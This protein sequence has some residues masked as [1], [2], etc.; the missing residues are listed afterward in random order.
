[1]IFP[2]VFAVFTALVVLFTSVQIVP[3]SLPTP[4]SIEK[5]ASEE[6]SRTVSNSEW[7]GPLAP[8][9]LSPFF[10]ITCLSGM[11]V[12]GDGT[13]VAD[14]HFVSTNPVLKQQAVFWIFLALTLLTSLPRLTKVSKPI[15]QILDQVETYAGIITLV[16][17]RF[18]A[19][20]E[21]EVTAMYQPE[22][23]RMGFLAITGDLLLVVAA[24]IN[25]FVINMVKFLFEALIWLTPFPMVDAV[26]EVCNKLFCAGLM[27]IYAWSPWV[28]MVINLVLFT[29]CALIFR[30]AY[31]SVAYFRAI[32]TDPVWKLI[33]PA[34]G[35]FGSKTELVVFPQ[36]EF[37]SFPKKSKLLL[38]RTE[39]GWRIVR[40]NFFLF[41]SQVV[42]L[43]DSDHEMEIQSGLFLNKLR[44]AGAHSGLLIFSRRYSGQL[45]RVATQMRVKPAATQSSPKETAIS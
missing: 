7:L 41:P 9:A 4:S 42:E 22:V 24:A 19:I 28:A 34:Y 23:M 30:W 26:F 38:S 36:D 45:D 14:N 25:I 17:I 2:R 6:I 35:H 20:P 29:I 21:A 13:F 43:S 8:I 16:V 27:A 12:F 40:R 44:V 31:R 10:G 5:E 1:M 33:R 18:M 32:L 3:H 11:S 15:A 37:A 39:N